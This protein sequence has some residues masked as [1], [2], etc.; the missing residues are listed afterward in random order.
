MIQRSRFMR[1]TLPLTLSLMTLLLPE[2]GAQPAISES[3]RDPVRVVTALGEAGNEK[4]SARE[5]AF[6]LEL[7][8]GHAFGADRWSR[9]KPEEKASVLRA[10]DLAVA[11]QL[12]DWA[13][14]SSGSTSILDH[15]T[16]GAKA[17]VL[18]LRGSDLLRVSLVARNNAW[19]IVEI[20]DLDS[21]IAVLGQTLRGALDSR[22]N[23]LRLLDIEPTRAL[24]E[25]DALISGQQDSAELL[26]L[27]A[28]VLS[29]KQFLTGLEALDQTKNANRKT[30]DPR[31]EAIFTLEKIIQRWPSF[32]PAY[33]QLARR[34][35]AN[36]AEGKR[37]IELY[38]SYARLMPVDPR[39]WSAIG[40]A[41][42]TLGDPVKAETAFGEAIRRSQN[43]LELHMDLLE[44][45]VNQNQL[46]K[47]KA[48][49]ATALKTAGPDDVFEWLE[50][51]IFPGFDVDIDPETARRYEL[52]VLQFPKELNSSKP[53]LRVLATSAQ[54][55]KK[56]LDAIKAV[57]RSILIK[58]EMEDY[59]SLSQLNRAAKRL[60]PALA[61]ADQ[62]VKMKPESGSAHLERAYALVGLNRHQEALSSLKRA[63]EL[64][65][66]L[67]E[68]LAGDEEL[69]PL[70]LLPAFKELIEKP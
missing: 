16:S 63:T 15:Q 5:L 55:Q 10:F 31:N 9:L 51:I 52:L 18:A 1:A 30:I 40:E 64:S 2:A 61:A 32:A 49:F 7:A 35:S 47:A 62:A 44:F 53:G 67:R 66:D 33:Y 70:A 38:E 69:K 26:L 56:Y 45:H 25:I 57:E 46:E 24:K 21:A 42:A 50:A 19:Y 60:R 8:G 29:R 37:K 58:A 3:Q 20:E 13:D 23:R 4:K 43:N 39:P 11:E 12:E 68:S 59:L 54:V 65:P 28:L 36:P 14:E 27:K 41:A 17:T 34:L 6:D 22:E 48:T